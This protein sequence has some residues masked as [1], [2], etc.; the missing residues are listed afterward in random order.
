MTSVSPSTAVISY[1]NSDGSQDPSNINPGFLS[2]DFSTGSANLS[3]TTDITQALC[4]NMSS[5]SNQVTI[6]FISSGA[7]V[8]LIWGLDPSAN[9][10]LS[11]KTTAA[12]NFFMNMNNGTVSIVDMGTFSTILT[13]SPQSYSP[14]T[15]ISPSS[16]LSSSKSSSGMAKFAKDIQIA[17]MGLIVLQVGTMA[18][19]V[20]KAGIKF[21]SK[22]GSKFAKFLKSTFGG[23]NDEL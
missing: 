14:V 1:G 19:K 15:S 8:Y 11:L 2:I 17:G 10:T 6:S 5:V 12:S 13:F 3:T 9:P 20:L 4:C 23:D 18:G 7:L 21:L 22:Y 16:S